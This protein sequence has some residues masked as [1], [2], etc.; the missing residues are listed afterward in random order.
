[1]VGC[2]HLEPHEFIEHCKGNHCTYW[3]KEVKCVEVDE[4][5][6]EEPRSTPIHF[7]IDPK[8]AV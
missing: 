5:I 6:D 8:G 7:L 3:D 1:M 4:K 2:Y